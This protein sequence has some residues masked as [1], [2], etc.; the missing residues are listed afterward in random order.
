MRVGRGVYPHWT[1]V[2][3]EAIAALP[4][5]TQ[6]RHLAIDLQPPFADPALDLATRADAGSGQ[7]FL[8]AIRGGQRLGLRQAR[9]ARRTRATT[10]GSRRSH[11]VA[12]VGAVFRDQFGRGRAVILAH[13]IGSRILIVIPGLLVHRIGFGIVCVQHIG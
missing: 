6:R 11:L 3:R 5:G 8:Q 7:H 2:E 1:A 9:G 4:F 12:V 13:G 10:R